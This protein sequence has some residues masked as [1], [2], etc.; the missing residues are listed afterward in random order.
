M[1]DETI[2]LIKNNN[3]VQSKYGPIDDRPIIKPENRR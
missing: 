1:D 2:Q 3:K